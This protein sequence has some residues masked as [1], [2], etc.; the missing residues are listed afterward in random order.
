MRVIDKRNMS[1]PQLRGIFVENRQ[2]VASREMTPV[3]LAKS[4]LADR[5]PVRQGLQ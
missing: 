1:V 5:T 2:N 3:G 4:P